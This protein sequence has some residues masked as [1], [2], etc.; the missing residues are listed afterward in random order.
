M[1][2]HYKN[3]IVAVDGS[4]EAEYA[5]RKSIDVSKRNKDSVLNIVNVIETH[6]FDAYDRS[7]VEQVQQRSEE[8]L[9]GYK[10]EAEAEGVENVKTVIKY[11]SPKNI[12]TGELAAQVKAV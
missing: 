8:L 12:I 9:K 5:L 11:G 2:N 7:V 4:K 6:A 3:I 1:A 10:E